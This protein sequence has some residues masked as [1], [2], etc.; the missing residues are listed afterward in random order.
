MPGSLL[1]EK[2]QLYIHANY[3]LQTINFMALVLGRD[4]AT[5]ST[6]VHALRKRSEKTLHFFEIWI[7]GKH[8]EDIT[9]DEELTDF[10]Q[11]SNIHEKYKLDFATRPYYIYKRIRARLPEYIEP[12]KPY[13]LRPV[14][15]GYTERKIDHKIPKHQPLVRAKW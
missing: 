2:E 3:K 14:P 11:L 6:C 1:T 13:P 5:V 9:K 8:V 7:S 4:R 12:T 10:Q 15:E